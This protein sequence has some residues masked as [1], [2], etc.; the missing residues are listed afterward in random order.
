[1][2]LKQ[3]IDARRAGICLY[4]FAPPKRA[5]PPE[6]LAALAVR[7]MARLKGLELDGLVIY[8]IQDEAERTPEPRPFP[9]LPTVPPEEYAELLSP[10]GL[11]M[12]IYRCVN[13]DT[14][15]SLTAWLARM[16]ARQGLAVLVGAPTRHAA[17]GV[18]LPEAYA[19]AR[20]HAPRLTLGGVAIA[21]R[22][23]RNLDEHQRMLAKSAAGCRFFVTQAVYDVTA[24]L[25]LLSDY[26]LAVEAAGQAPVPVMLTFSPCGSPKTLAFMKWLGI[27]F[28][29]WLEN[30]LLRSSQPLETSIAVCRRIFAECWDFAA[31]KGIPLGVN[32]ES[33]SIRK[34]EI[35][36][37]IELA[38]SL[39]AVMHP[40]TRDE[41]SVEAAGRRS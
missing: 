20:K 33:I 27:H 21:E 26:A 19:L 34:A 40:T 28:P 41:H 29:R 23:A 37:S 2:D 16:D 4:G 38:R 32:V 13:R 3:S 15:E 18:K 31:A 14:H 7:Q 1:M 12:I 5:T 39:R 17:R 35:D 10:L 24:T 9:F 8:D 22:H 11:P 36:A 25:S 30:E 6:E